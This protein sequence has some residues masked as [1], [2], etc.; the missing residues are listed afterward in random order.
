ME[1]AE[2]TEKLVTE[3]AVAL[4]PEVSNET[5][6]PIGAAVETI[7]GVSE[8]AVAEENDDDNIEWNQAAPT[9]VST[10]NVESAQSDVSELKAQLEA[11]ISEIAR[12]KAEIDQVGSIKEDPLVRAWFEYRQADESPT[13][14][15]FLQDVGAVSFS[16]ADS[17]KGEDLMREYVT[18]LAKNSGISAEDLSD[19]VE[20]ELAGYYNA[21]RLGRVE[22]ERK[23]KEF[24]TS[25]KKNTIEGLENELK[26]K[27]KKDQE[28]QLSWIKLQ[29]DNLVDYLNK[30][31]DKGKYNGRKVDSKWREEI[32]KIAD[33]SNDVFN[34]N[35]VSYTTK[36]EKGVAHLYTPSVVDFID[37]AKNRE[38]LRG[39]GKRKVD[40]AKGSNLEE[41]A[42]TAH[43]T[44]ISA[45]KGALTIAESDLSYYDAWQ[46]ANGK[47]HKQDPRN[48]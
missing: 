28:S 14:A 23:A 39:I 20:E 15:G 24:F 13:V 36:D 1:A 18:E 32:L 25:G 4:T 44:Q 48:K 9:A 19:A 2:M 30:V 12:L 11:S 17:L 8:S 10:S 16:K 5:E 40:T 35:F 7:A 33:T 6:K 29:R 45:E 47:M 43:N 42:I 27:N 26:E 38:E 31:V 41:K 22:F 46:K 21:T 34:P 37:S 3:E